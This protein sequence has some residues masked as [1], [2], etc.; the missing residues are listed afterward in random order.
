MSVPTVPEAPAGGKYCREFFDRAKPMF[1][2][3]CGKELAP[4]ATSC[5]SC[6]A[7]VFY[8]PP[9]PPGSP[10]TDP[11]DQIAADLKRVAQEFASTAAQLSRRVA[12][13]AEAAAKDPSAEAKKTARKVAQDID[14]VAK[15]IDR[16]LRDL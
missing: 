13:K 14:A 5:A 3:N 16:L 6:G 11:V 12:A 8:P 10:S 7:R 4:G 2:Q 9:P 15:E 1:C